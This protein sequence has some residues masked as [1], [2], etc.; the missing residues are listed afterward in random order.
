MMI[1][2]NVCSTLVLCGVTVFQCVPIRYIFYPAR[3]NLPGSDA[4]CLDSYRLAISVP[5][6]NLG[7]DI[8]VALLPV[9]MIMAISL[10]VRSKAMIL[11]MLGLGALYAIP[12]PPLP[13]LLGFSDFF[14]I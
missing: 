5:S 4:R 11:V 10:P 3:I 6:V 2:I 1:V 13:R 14:F 12:Q 7:L 9:R 8:A